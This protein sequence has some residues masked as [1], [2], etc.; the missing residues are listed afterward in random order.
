MTSVTDIIVD[1]VEW[2]NTNLDIFSSI[3]ID[4]C[5]ETNVPST[6]IEYIQSNW[7]KIDDSNGGTFKI[8]LVAPELKRCTNHDKILN[9]KA[10]E[11]L[12]NAGIEA[13]IEH[14]FTDHETGRKLTYSEMR[15]L[16]G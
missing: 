4:K 8:K 12:Y 14:M 13:G 15:D 6:V 11:V 7:T 16:Y 10:K 3:S 1:P 9:M 2:I 5:K